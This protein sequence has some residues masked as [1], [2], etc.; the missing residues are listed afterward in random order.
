MLWV[1]SDHKVVQKRTSQ[2]Y[3]HPKDAMAGHSRRFWRT[4]PR[5][6]LKPSSFTQENKISWSD[7]N[8]LNSTPSSDGEAENHVCHTRY[9]EAARKRKR[10]PV[11]FKGIWA[12]CLEWGIPSSPRHARTCV[13]RRRCIEFYE[14]AKQDRAKVL[15]S[16]KCWLASSSPHPL[17]E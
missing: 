7:K 13:S 14:T 9:A 6:A 8:S 11:Q 5:R 4:I 16:K 17:Q 12:I 1:P 15:P 2:S 3:R 10:F